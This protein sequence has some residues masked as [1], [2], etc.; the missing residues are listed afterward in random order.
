MITRRA[1]LALSAAALGLSFTVSD[2]RAQEFPQRQVTIIVPYPAG[3]FIDVATR[4]LAE[5]L[6]ERWG[7]PVIVINKPGANGKIGLTELVRSPPDGHILLTNNDGGI[8]LP[9]ALDGS[10]NFDFRKDYTPVAQIVETKFVIALNADVPAKNIADFIRYG[11][12]NPGKLNYA[13]PGL[14]TTPH[15]AAEYFSQK[16]G[17]KMVHV[18]Y[19]GAA[20]AVTDLVNGI[21]N[22]YFA[23]VPSIAAHLQSP[24]L[25][26]IGTLADER[27]ASLPA[28]PTMAEAGLE[29][30][31]VTSWLGLFA[32]PKL[33]PAVA[34]RISNS[35]AE[36]VR[37]P[38]WRE[39][40][41]AM[42]TDPITKDAAT[43]AKFYVSEVEKWSE[44]SKRTGIRVG[45]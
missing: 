19:V 26:I 29:G 24:R 37:D 17:L 11:R 8:A 27:I 22:V 23:T 6:R 44:F 5:G 45:K 16:T 33:D 42:H 9:P 31:I 3:G 43:F 41:R 40:F 28:A 36:V 18:P 10:F 20:P 32:P 35:V 21:V 15:I 2:L 4:I 7:K 14:G 34:V 1:A 12:D 13:S 38:K 39:R 30:L 25:R